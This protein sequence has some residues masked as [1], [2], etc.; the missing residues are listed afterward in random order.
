MLRLLDTTLRDGSYVNNFSFDEKDTKQ[1][2]QGLLS[3]SVD[4][5]EIGHG[6]GLGGFRSFGSDSTLSD[7]AYINAAQSTNAN[8][9][10]MFCIPGIC[11]QED[12]LRALDSNIH[13]I[14]I[15]GTINE[16]KEIFKFI[17]IAKRKNILVS[18]NFMKSYMNTPLEFETAAREVAKTGA[19]IV[20]LVDSAGAMLP[21][22]V[23]QFCERL[24]GVNFGF[25]GHENL[26]LGVANS[27]IAIECGAKIIDASLQRLGRSSGNT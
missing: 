13:F 26:G 6:V 11:T 4:L 16:T 17:E 25:H 3:A 19:D 21:N 23:R 7:A 12:L 2:I 27:L 20:Y 14:R 18:V 22:Q 9:W 10:G 15:G 5:I 1:I 24:E 8:N